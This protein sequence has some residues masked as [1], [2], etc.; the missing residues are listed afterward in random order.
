MLILDEFPE[1]EYLSTGNLRITTLIGLSFF[2]T[3]GAYYILVW[4]K[5]AVRFSKSLVV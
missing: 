3:S 2:T 5:L 1:E 4:L